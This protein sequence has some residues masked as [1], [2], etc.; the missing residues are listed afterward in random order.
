M[1]ELHQP[2]FETETEDYQMVLL[3]KRDTKRERFRLHNE[4]AC[5]ARALQGYCTTVDLRND[6]YVT[7]TISNVDGYS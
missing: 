6:N 5:L 3:N 4:L 2:Q 7:G 1:A